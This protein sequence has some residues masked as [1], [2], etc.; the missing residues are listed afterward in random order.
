MVTVDSAHGY[1]TVSNMQFFG[2]TVA[3]GGGASTIL[4]E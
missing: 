1:D 4:H 3:G 2:D